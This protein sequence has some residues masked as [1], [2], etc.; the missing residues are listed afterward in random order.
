MLRALRWFARVTLGGGSQASRILGDLE[1]GHR[2]LGRG[3]AGFAQDLVGVGQGEGG[4]IVG[5]RDFQWGEVT[6]AH[7]V[8]RRCVDV[9]RNWG[10]T[11]KRA[12]GGRRRVRGEEAGG[13]VRR[14]SLDA[15]VDLVV[16]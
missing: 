13:R 15:D 2:R 10:D 12:V 1:G 5:K 14:R 4:I 6:G 16:L 11:L 3:L 8:R 9:S 7:D